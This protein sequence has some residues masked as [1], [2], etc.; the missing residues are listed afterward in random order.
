M[1]MFTFQPASR[2]LQA[3]DFKG[4]F[5]H[6]FYKV[7]QPSFLL[8]ATKRTTADQQSRVGIVVAKRKIRR[9]HER[10]RFKR[11]T[12]ESFRLNQHVLPALDIVVMAKQ[13]ADLLPNADLHQELHK[14]WHMLQQ[15]VKKQATSAPPPSSQTL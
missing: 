9:A 1:T 5:D 10:N 3:S 7:H 2:L 8:L 14:A 13:G 11:L 12:R 15:R 6:A 4:V